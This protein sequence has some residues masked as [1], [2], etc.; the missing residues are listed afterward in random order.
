MLII[1]LILLLAG[2]VFPLYSFGCDYTSIGSPYSVNYGNIIVQRDV[3]VGQAISNEIYGSMALGYSCT[4]TGNEGSSAGMK[5]AGLTYAFTS[6]N[7]RRVFNTGLPGVGISLGY[8]EKNT[9]GPATYM[10]TTWLAAD[11]FTASWST[12]P[13]ENDTYSFQPI[14]QFWKTGPITSGSVSGQ[15]AAFV[16]WEAQYRGGATA[17]DIPVYAGTGSITQVACAITTPNLVFPIGEVLA[18]SFGSTVGTTPSGAQMTQNL[19]LNCDSGANI[20]ATLTGIQNPDLSDDSV[21]ALSGQGSEGVASG[22]GV[23]LLY[24]GS[25]LRL[26]R[27]MVLKQTSGGQESLPITARYYQTQTSV[28]TGTA[29]T[30]ATLILTYQ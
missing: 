5:S 4:A 9:A 19:G 16:A 13:G 22:V 21:L 7:G 14:I 25:P 11:M 28:S 10:G 1:R 6:A 20:N 8:Y 12:N 27:N 3:P 23:Q 18:S 2:V 17:P 15:L 26:N 29:N 30:S 24:N